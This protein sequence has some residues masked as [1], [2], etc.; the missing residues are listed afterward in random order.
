MSLESCVTTPIPEFGC[1]ATGVEYI[2]RPGGYAVI[3]SP[4]GEVAVV[5]TS[6]G[7]ALPGGG[8]QAGESPEDAAIRETREECGLRIVLGT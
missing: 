2:L 6:L 7:L 1:P 8:Q 4:D 5:A 3:F